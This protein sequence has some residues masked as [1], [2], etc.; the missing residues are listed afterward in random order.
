MWL[1]CA[2]PIFAVVYA[3][4]F[5]SLQRSALFDRNATIAVSLCTT[6]L[7]MFGL[8][9]IF[10]RPAD[11]NETVA[12]ERDTG[13]DFLLIP[14]AA[15][16][17]VILSVLLLSFAQKVLGR[18]DR[19]SPRLETFRRKE[20]SHGPK[21]CGDRPRSSQDL[22]RLRQSSELAKLRQGNPSD[23]LRKRL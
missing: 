8:Y 2:L 9:G 1:L 17:L 20:R 10:V 12:G 7:C 3:A 18:R 22:R 15:L 5:A 4:I 16:A 23:D 14:Y 6:L 21:E 11:T 19:R 13:L